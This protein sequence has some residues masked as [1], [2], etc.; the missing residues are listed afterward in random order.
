MFFNGVIVRNRLQVIGNSF[1]RLAMVRGLS[2]YLGQVVVNEFPKSGGTWLGQML[3]S[4]LGLPFPRNTWPRLGPSILH[5][6]YLDPFGM[7]R[8][9][10][11]WR[12]G[13]DVMVSW[14]YHNLFANERESQRLVKR[15]QR[16]L[17]FEELAN[18]R[19]NLPSFLEYAFTEQVYPRFTWVEFTR[20]WCGRKGIVHAR[21][22]D[23]RRGTAGELQRVVRD[24]TGDSLPWARAVSVAKEF[25]FE[26]QS[27]RKPGQENS[28]SFMRKGIV[29]DWKNAFTQEAKEIFHRYAGDA[30]VRLGYEKDDSWVRGI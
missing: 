6:H 13:R 27:G 20:V 29:G 7:K 22:E 4:A 9:V 24:L 30:L 14:Y 11:M 1:L 2:R 8:V 26:R 17:H 15:V 10:V 16:V 28:W 3:G 23:L 5:G 19:A 18:I 21:Y 25:S 12:D